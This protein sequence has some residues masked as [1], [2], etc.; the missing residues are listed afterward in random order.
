LTALNAEEV[1]GDVLG[2]I[3]FV[4]EFRTLLGDF[5]SVIED[6]D[7]GTF[8][9]PGGGT[10]T[11]SIVDSPPSGEISK[12]DSAS[13]AF[14]GC[15][16]AMDG[17]SVTL[18]GSLGFSVNDVADVP[19]PGYD[20]LV[21]FSFS[22]LAMA[23]GTETVTVSGGFTAHASTPDGVIVTTVVTGDSLRASILSPGVSESARISDFDDEEIT[24]EGTGAFTITTAGTLYQSEIGGEVDY[25]T[26]APLEG[27]NPNPPGAGTLLVNGGGG[28]SMLLVAVDEV[29]ARLDVDTDGDGIRETVIHTTWSA[30]TD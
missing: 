8:P 29:N 19:P 3:E 10:M 6:L 1:A 16:I 21:R 30:L 25:E 23:T 18:N 7:S 11:L 20:A 15:S 13:F 9:C 14:R 28:T 4:A 2:A 22:N 26:I 12:G 27:T 5:V 17:G 24:D